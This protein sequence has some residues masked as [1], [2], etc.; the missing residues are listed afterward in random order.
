MHHFVQIY[1]IFFKIKYQLI[2]N[3]NNRG[4]LRPLV[5]TLS[6]GHQTSDEGHSK[7]LS[8]KRSED[9][10]VINKQEYT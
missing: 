2:N 9:Q 10:I 3:E 1:S 8:D 5:L 4:T 6:F 7:M